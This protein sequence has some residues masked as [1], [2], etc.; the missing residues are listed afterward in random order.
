MRWYGHCEKAAVLVQKTDEG[1]TVPN[2]VSMVGKTT[3][4]VTFMNSLHR[5]AGVVLLPRH[6]K[7]ETTAIC[8][9]LGFFVLQQMTQNGTAARRVCFSSPRSFG[10]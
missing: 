9:R 7:T 10:R 3:V 2:L 4:N 1:S 5:G 8:R 6:S